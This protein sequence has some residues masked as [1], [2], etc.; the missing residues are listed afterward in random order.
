ARVAFGELADA[1]R[2]DLRSLLAQMELAYSDDRPEEV[3]DVCAAAA[4]LVGDY[5]LRA[6]LHVL[7]GRLHERAHRH[8]EAGAPPAPPPPTPP[9]RRGARPR[10]PP[11][12]P[13]PGAAAPGGGA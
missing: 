11:P 10:P 4:P 7:G 12:P 13:P 1:R 2:D 5:R 9:P 6:A 3:I 8:V